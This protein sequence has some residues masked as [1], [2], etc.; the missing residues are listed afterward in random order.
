MGEKE[1]NIL[2][3]INGIGFEQIKKGNS[4]SKIPSAMASNPDLLFEEII[5]I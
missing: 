2:L 4:S 3:T 1:E 5:K